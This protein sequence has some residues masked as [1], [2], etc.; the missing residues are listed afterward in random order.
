MSLTLHRPC[1]GRQMCLWD[2][3]IFPPI[4]AQGLTNKHDD[5][6]R[7]LEGGIFQYKSQWK[8]H[9]HICQVVKVRSK[10]TEVLRNLPSKLKY[11]IDQND[12]FWTDMLYVVG[13]SM[14]MHLRVL[15]YSIYCTWSWVT[16]VFNAVIFCVRIYFRMTGKQY[17]LFC[18][19]LWN[20]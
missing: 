8:L 3:P 18:A 1:C 6:L 20:R 10:K 14:G 13:V 12:I 19:T 7:V 5:W 15:Y 2:R 9:P 16:R 4:R 11:L 17:V